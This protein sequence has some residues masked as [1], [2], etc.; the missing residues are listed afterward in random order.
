VADSAGRRK[1]KFVPLTGLFLTG[2]LKDC[3]ARSQMTN[4][5]GRASPTAFLVTQAG[6]RLSPNVSIC[7]EAT[8]LFLILASQT[9]GVDQDRMKGEFIAYTDIMPHLAQP[10]ERRAKERRQGDQASRRLS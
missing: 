6:T 5:L 7:L 8:H 2:L 9:G 1:V 10:K 3:L 4:N